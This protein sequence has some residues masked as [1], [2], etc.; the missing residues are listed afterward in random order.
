M[1]PLRIRMIEDMRTAG[2]TSGTQSIYL[3]GVRRLTAHYGR[4]SCPAA[5]GLTSTTQSRTAGPR[6]WTVTV[7]VFPVSKFVTLVVVPSGSALRAATLWFG[8]ILR[9]S[10]ILCPANFGA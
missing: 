9:P 7:A 10:A 1:T 2:L 4:L 5:F 3:D 6:S 8:F